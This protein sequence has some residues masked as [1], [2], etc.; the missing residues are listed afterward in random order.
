MERMRRFSYVVAAMAC[1]NGGTLMA[2]KGNS[3]EPDA[4]K[5][6]GEEVEEKVDDVGDKVEEAGDDIEDEVDEST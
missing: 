2:C 4:D 5:T 6:T 1:L 3:E